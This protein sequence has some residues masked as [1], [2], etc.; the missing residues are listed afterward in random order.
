MHSKYLKYFMLD[1]LKNAT[2][3]FFLKKKMLPETSVQRVSLG[4]EGFRFVYKACLNS[5]PGIF[6]VKKPKTEGFQAVP[7]CSCAKSAYA[8]GSTLFIK[9]S[10]SD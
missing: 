3:I 4:K 10:S 7:L 8:Q 2:G 5:G 9:F 1:E 6:S